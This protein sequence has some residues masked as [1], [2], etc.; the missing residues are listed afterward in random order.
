MI[1]TFIEYDPENDTDAQEADLVRLVAE[2]EFIVTNYGTM[3]PTEG[4]EVKWGGR[5][6]Q[7][8]NEDGFDNWQNIT[9]G[10]T[11]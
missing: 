9:G 1:Y 11:R 2:C 5:G 10:Y 3:Y 6:P 4:V 8:H 7:V